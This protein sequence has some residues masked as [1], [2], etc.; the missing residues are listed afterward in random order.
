MGWN[1]TARKEDGNV[2]VLKE[3]TN[4]VPWEL[5]VARAS[6]VV[7]WLRLWASKAGGIRL[8]LWLGK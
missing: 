8:N 3:K 4:T 1:F 2:C 6:L 7:Q 5:K